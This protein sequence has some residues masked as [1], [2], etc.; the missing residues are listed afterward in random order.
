MKK[1]GFLFIL[2]VMA[3]VICLHPVI[4]QES[5]NSL[6]TA[7]KTGE[8]AAVQGDAKTIEALFE[9]EKFTCGLSVEEREL[10][11]ESTTFASD[12]ERIY[13]WCLITGC[14]EPTIVEHVWYYGGVEKAR[15]A[16]DIKYPRV[17]TW[18]YKTMLPEWT[19]DWS[20]ELV[21][22]KG[23]VLAKTEF[24]VE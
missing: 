19:G 13:C 20:V 6:P 2:C 23:D 17:R 1:T 21:N 15:V 18:S 14:E 16:L 24:R 7:K 10:L 11:G 8:T 4:A 12:A 3:G 22:V 9:V 5:E